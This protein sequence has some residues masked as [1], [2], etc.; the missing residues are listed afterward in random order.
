M[1]PGERCVRVSTARIG[2]ASPIGCISIPVASATTVR[3][4]HAV[5]AKGQSARVSPMPASCGR[6]NP[7]ADT[8]KSVAAST[9]PARPAAR[10]LTNRRPPRSVAIESASRAASRVIAAESPPP[11]ASPPEP[12]S[13]PDASRLR[14]RA[15]SSARSI[16]S[17]ISDSLGRNRSAGS[18][19]RRT[20]T[21]PPYPS[22]ARCNTRTGRGSRNTKSRTTSTNTAATTNA[23]VRHHAS[24][25]STAR[26]RRP[27]RST[28][29]RAGPRRRPAAPVAPELC[30]SR[31][32]VNA[33]VPSCP[34]AAPG[35]P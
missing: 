6:N 2:S 31:V 13:S 1:F 8:T 33:C 35:P 30:L 22:A 27:T 15:A 10:A 25:S 28:S 16:R 29:S 20:T 17:A 12:N 34:R 26:A 24:A 23:S 18:N 11:S 3:F 9:I 19:T 7:A 32:P 14:A 21:Y 5:P 4:G